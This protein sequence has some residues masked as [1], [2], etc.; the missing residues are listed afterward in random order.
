MYCIITAMYLFTGSMDRHEIYTYGIFGGAKLELENFFIFLAYL[1]PLFY[2]YSY[3]YFYYMA[4]LY[5]CICSM[6]RRSYDSHLYTHQETFNISYLRYEPIL[7]LRD[8]CVWAAV[9]FL[10]S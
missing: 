4:V 6:L 2:S 5:I 1:C 8:H 9:S 10:L 7:K 3:P